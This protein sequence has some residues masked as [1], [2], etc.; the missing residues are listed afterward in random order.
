MHL[1][2]IVPFRGVS[3]F[4]VLVLL[5]SLLAGCQPG[6]SSG[7]GATTTEKPQDPSQSTT[8]ST[9]VPTTE[10]TPEPTPTTMPQP[11]QLLA[12][13]PIVT[14]YFG[15]LPKAEMYTEMKHNELRALYIGAAANIDNVIA[16]CRTTE[17]NSVVID[18]KESDGIKYASEV[19]LAR[20]IGVVKP[21]YKIRDVLDRLHAEDIKVIGRIVCFKDPLLATARPDMSIRDQ[22]GNQLLFKNEGGK[23]FVD[24][25]NQDVWQYNIDL[26]LEAIEFGIDEIQF[27]YVRFPTGGTRSGE[28]PW[29]GAEGTVPTRVQAINRFLQ[30]AAI[31]IQHERG[32]P[33]GADVFGIIL[34]SKNDGNNLGQDWETIGLTGID[35]VAPM[36]YPSHYANS[37]TN[38]YTG[39]GRGTNLGGKLFT[40]PDLEPYEVMYQAL[41]LGKAMTEQ[42]G[43]S[44]NRPYLQAFTASYLPSGYYKEYQAADI[45]A[46]IK[47]IYDAGY[48]EWICWNPRATYTANSFKPAN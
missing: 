3:I 24:P 9:S 46:Q 4:L 30:T 8:G 37:S 22:K 11:E 16:I 15:P 21:A 39:N 27:D 47:A 6:D 25:Y 10:P 40:K 45:K 35:N 31:H 43:Y 34:S 41:M 36:I 13:D 12:E 5:I 42:A 28:K 18:L 23:A 14:D 7:T 29:F 32:I 44:V 1:K 38:H 26:A 33:L 20:E 2:K 48:K 17:V 19:P